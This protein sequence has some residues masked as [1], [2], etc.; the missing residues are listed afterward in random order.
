MK[1]L[2]LFLVLLPKCIYS[3][4]NSRWILQKDLTREIAQCPKLPK[5]IE[6]ALKSNHLPYGANKIGTHFGKLKKTPKGHFIAS[7]QNI[8]F[9]YL[10]S[11]KLLAGILKIFWDPNLDV[12]RKNGK[13]KMSLFVENSRF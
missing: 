3:F 13:F 4:E 12:T 9:E 5:P 6:T 2:L 8:D 11:E 7:F 10:Q 1:F